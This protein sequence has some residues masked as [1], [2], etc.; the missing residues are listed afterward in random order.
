MLQ[1]STS[2]LLLLAATLLLGSCAV[3]EPPQQ[4]DEE[5]DAGAI[6][7]QDA[8][9]ADGGFDAGSTDTSADP[10]AGQH[11]DTGPTYVPPQFSY[12]A[13]GGGLSTSPQ[14][15]MQMGFG[16]PM[17][18]GTSSNGQYRLRFGPVSP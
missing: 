5:T 13:S 8:I 6:T 1:R 10:D 17:P 18:R 9:G 12:P 14:F 16:A 2:V 11:K 3:G 4:G 7:D 15:R